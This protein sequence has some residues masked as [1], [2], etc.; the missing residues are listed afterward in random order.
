MLRP[1]K[2]AKGIFYRT[3]GKVFALVAQK[4]KGGFGS[5]CLGSIKYNHLKTILLDFPPAAGN[6]FLLPF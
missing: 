4:P 1:V 2:N 6:L 5:F 3:R